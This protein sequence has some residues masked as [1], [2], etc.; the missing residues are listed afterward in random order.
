MGEKK[1]GIYDGWNGTNMYFCCGK[2]SAREKILRA[3]N[4]EDK[5]N[6]LSIN[7]KLF[8]YEQKDFYFVCG[9]ANA[10]YNSVCGKCA[11]SLVRKSRKKRA[12]C[13]VW[14]KGRYKRLSIG[15]IISGSS[16]AQG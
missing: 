12:C 6:L 14:R 16:R 9:F 11:K 5:I 1:I 4:I 8:D 3:L 13:E 15:G 7:I 2:K 10:V